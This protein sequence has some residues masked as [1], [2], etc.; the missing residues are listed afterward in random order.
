MKDGFAP[1][2]Q[3]QALIAMNHETAMSGAAE[4]G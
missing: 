1:I 3:N 2:E 4:R